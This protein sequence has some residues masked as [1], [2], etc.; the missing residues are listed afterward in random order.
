MIIRRYQESDFEQMVQLQRET[1]I[2]ENVYRGDGYWEE[3]LKDIEEY[4]FNNNGYF[5]VGLELDRIISMGA[6][7]KI[8]DQ[9]AEL[10]R[11]RVHPD[12]QGVGIGFKILLE[13]EKMARSK[14][15]KEIILETDERLNAAI[16]LY[17][18]N[19]YL[20]WRVEEIS[21][22]NCIWYKKQL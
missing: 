16:N 8:D 6:F 12:F 19:G 9:T 4:Y 7:R 3:G 13:L 1:L 20:F 17:L 22:C 14:N 5:I 15:Y 21:G 11:M 18:K 2:R 10:V